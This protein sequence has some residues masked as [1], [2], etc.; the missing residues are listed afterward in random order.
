MLYKQHIIFVRHPS[1]PQ[2]VKIEQTDDTTTITIS[3]GADI[4]VDQTW[5]PDNVA[6]QM[7]AG[8][9]AQAQIEAAKKDFRVVLTTTA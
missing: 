3:P 9:I 5:D 4:E 7:A 2:A 1:Q 6:H 8:Q